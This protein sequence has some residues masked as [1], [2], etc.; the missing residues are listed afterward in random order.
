MFSL[1][2]EFFFFASEPFLAKFLMVYFCW[3]PFFWNIGAFKRAE[4]LRQYSGLFSITVLKTFVL[5]FQFFLT[6]GTS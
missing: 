1:A 3:C 6:C 5:A 4:T 2:T